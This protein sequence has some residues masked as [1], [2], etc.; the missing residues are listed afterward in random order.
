MKRKVSV[1][2][3]AIVQ[4]EMRKEYDFRDGMRGK[5]YKAYRKGHWLVI[6]KADGSVKL[7]FYSVSR[8]V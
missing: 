5:H 2:A 7:S 6:H 1:R 3:K 8:S 4:S